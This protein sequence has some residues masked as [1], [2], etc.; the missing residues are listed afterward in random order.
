[1]KETADMVCGR[2][3]LCFPVFFCQFPCDTFI[4][5]NLKWLAKWLRYGGRRLT[6]RQN[7]TQISNLKFGL[8]NSFLV[9]IESYGHG[10]Y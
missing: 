9:I 1:M 5:R 6:L 3:Y 8:L 7:Q 2:Q 4:P 10:Y